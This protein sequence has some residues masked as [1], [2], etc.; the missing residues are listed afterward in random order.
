MIVADVSRVRKQR[1]LRTDIRRCLS[2]LACQLLH[3]FFTAV[4]TK[5]VVI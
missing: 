4:A 5:L 3:L 1:T 2:F